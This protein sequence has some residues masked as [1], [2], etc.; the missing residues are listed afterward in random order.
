MTDSHYSNYILHE[1]ISIKLTKWIFILQSP[2]RVGI[3]DSTRSINRKAKE[4]I[5]GN[6]NR[7]WNRK[8]V[9]D[10]QLNGTTN[11]LRKREIRFLYST[12]LWPFKR[13]CNDNRRQF[14]QRGYSLGTSRMSLCNS[15]G[16]SMHSIISD[17]LHHSSLVLQL[18]WRFVLARNGGKIPKYLILYTF[19]ISLIL[20]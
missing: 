16:T 15:L 18:L 3:L 19:K 8:Q 2:S 7:L 11:F 14:W 20:G 10:F 4:G 17:L 12:D 13:F 5:V 6:P 1:F 9:Q